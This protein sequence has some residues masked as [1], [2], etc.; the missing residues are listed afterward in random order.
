M[1]WEALRSREAKRSPA[2]GESTK[3]QGWANSDE[4]VNHAASGDVADRDRSSRTVW[5][6]GAPG[7]GGTQPRPPRLRAGEGE[8]RRA[9]QRDLPARLPARRSGSPLRRA[10]VGRHHPV[11]LRSGDRA[12]LQ[13]ARRGRCPRVRRSRAGLP[14]QR[15]L[16]FSQRSAVFAPD[17]LLEL[18]RQRRLPDPTRFRPRH[19]D[20]RAWRQSNPDR[21]QHAIRRHRSGAPQGRPRRGERLHHD[22]GPDRRSESDRLLRPHWQ[23]P[24]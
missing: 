7:I 20:W 5:T 2:A 18:G 11:R 17:P 15:P 13:R 10:D 23:L 8:H 14:W 12:N 9:G 6:D 21:R 24:G 16:R 1:A 19:S 3:N 4:E 22:G